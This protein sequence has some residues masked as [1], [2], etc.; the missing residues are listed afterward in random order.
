MSRL[1]ESFDV[2]VRG[3]G[4][5]SRCVQKGN[6]RSCVTAKLLLVVDKQIYLESGVA[7]VRYLN[8]ETYTNVWLEVTLT[9][10]IVIEASYIFE[11]RKREIV[12]AVG[13]P[14]GLQGLKVAYNVVRNGAVWT[15]YCDYVRR[16]FWNHKAIFLKTVRRVEIEG[17]CWVKCRIVRSKKLRR[18]VVSVVE[19]S[20]YLSVGS[21]N[22]DC[23]ARDAQFVERLSKQLKE[24]CVSDCRR[25]SC[26]HVHYDEHEEARA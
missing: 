17:A 13:A 22:I 10:N 20:S 25:N 23:S 11:V 5:P 19:E 8:P 18:P 12:D 1:I 26:S 24:G 14:V 7:R 6:A 9:T 4:A 21:H 2:G 3:G 16:D 15:H